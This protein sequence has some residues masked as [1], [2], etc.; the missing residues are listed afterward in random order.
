[1]SG[2]RLFSKE[3]VMVPHPH[4]HTKAPHRKGRRSRR[5]RSISHTLP[6]GWSDHT[7]TSRT[8]TLPDR[9]SPHQ[10]HLVCSSSSNL[11]WGPWVSDATPFPDWGCLASRRTAIGCRRCNASSLRSRSDIWSGSWPPWIRCNPPGEWALSHLHRRHRRDKIAGQRW[12]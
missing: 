2:N 10:P 8:H 9:C 4:L 11:R 7:H 5:S 3:M 12:S 6:R 1:M